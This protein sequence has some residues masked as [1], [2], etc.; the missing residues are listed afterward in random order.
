MLKDLGL[1]LDAAESVGAPLYTGKVAADV[2]SSMVDAGCV[3][4]PVWTAD[5]VDCCRCYCCCYLASLCLASSPPSL[6]VCAPSSMATKDFS[7]AYK[8]ASDNSKSDE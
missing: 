8:F 3:R 1:A 5:V 2:Y 7:A 6:S 4:A